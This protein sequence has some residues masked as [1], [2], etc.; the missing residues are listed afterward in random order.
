M[1]S[2]FSVLW[3][4]ICTYGWILL[5]VIDK[6]CHRFWFAALSITLKELLQQS[7]WWWWWFYEM[8]YWWYMWAAYY[9]GLGGLVMVMIVLKMLMMMILIIIENTKELHHS[10][11]WASSWS[12]ISKVWATK[13][14]LIQRF[15]GENIEQCRCKQK[16]NKL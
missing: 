9:D 2:Y 13:M 6:V 16:R 5:L 10:Q 14:F 15:F 7:C 1:N 4:S 3:W 11:A 12:V 8:W